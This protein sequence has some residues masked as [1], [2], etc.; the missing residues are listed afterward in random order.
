M[1]LTH[2]LGCTVCIWNHHLK[3]KVKSDH[4]KYHL[5]IDKFTYSKSKFEIFVF[6]IFWGEWR[7]R[8]ADDWRIIWKFI[9]KFFSLSLNILFTHFIFVS[10]NKFFHFIPVSLVSKSLDLTH[11]W[12][13]RLLADCTHIALLL[14][15]WSLDWQ[16]AYHLE[17]CKKCRFS[18]P[19]RNYWI[20]INTLV[21][22]PSDLFVY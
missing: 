14:Q 19:I 17:T 1:L 21:R 3:N 12:K 2:L 11:T 15:V 20:R 5:I 10:L 6:Q 4:I 13:R 8:M 22:S 9:L 16:H 18:G 7:G